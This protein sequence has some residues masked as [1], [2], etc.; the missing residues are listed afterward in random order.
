MS[1]LIIMLPFALLIS[2]GFV[3]AFIYAVKKG[4]FDDLDTPAYR[5]LLDDENI[6]SENDKSI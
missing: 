1:V 2:I 3:L 6:K 5:V 4:Q